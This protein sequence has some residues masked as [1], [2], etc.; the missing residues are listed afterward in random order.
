MSQVDCD[1]NIQ[2]D[3]DLN[4]QKKNN[5][6]VSKI[7][8]AR[9]RLIS[10][11]S[12]KE[13][14]PEDKSDQHNPIHISKSFPN[15]HG[16]WID[17]IKKAKKVKDPWA[18]FNIAELY[19]TERVQ[20]YRYQASKKK[21]IQ[22]IIFVKMETE[23]F[24]KGAMRKCFRMK[25]LPTTVHTNDWAY[26]NN[27]VAKIHMNETIMA[28]QYFDDVKLQMDAKLWAEEYNRRDP[29]KKIDIMQQ[30]CCKFIHR[31]GQPMYH[32]ENFIEGNYVKYNS[33]TGFVLHEEDTHV[34][35]TPQAFSHF[36]FERSGHQLII[37]DIQGVGD[38]YT[39]PQIHT[40][41]GDDYGD[42]N[43]GTKGMALFFG[44]HQCTEL[45]EK[46]NLK[47][48]DLSE[49]E[50]KRIDNAGSKS[51]SSTELKS[52]TFSGSSRRISVNFEIIKSISSSSL[53]SNEEFSEPP[54][55][56]NVFDDGNDVNNYFEQH[57]HI[58][59]SAAPMEELTQELIKDRLNGLANFQ[60]QQISTLGKVH[61]ELA[62]YNY[63]GRFT[64]TKPD[65]SSALFHLYQAA[66]C[67]DLSA[68][69]ILAYKYFNFHTDEFEDLLI[70]EDH[71]LGMNFMIEAAT[72]ND[73]DCMMKTAKAFD[74]GI[75][76]GKK[77]SQC[78]KE[79][80]KWYEAALNHH[81]AFS[82]LDS[83]P[84]HMIKAR[85]AEIWRCGGYGVEK[86]PSY[87]GEL[88]SSAAE[89]ALQLGK[90][91]LANSYLMLAE[92]SFGEVEE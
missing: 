5:S 12:I 87:A 39:D 49:E 50:K 69:K 43:L 23:P 15:S 73:K 62:T 31:E 81:S 58:S 9:S 36:T 10:Y 84:K 38:L 60:E 67:G 65:F 64:D 27:I 91:K 3:N 40:A 47:K 52:D 8:K 76:L 45:C 1:T 37:V 90:G 19:P 29:P 18:E 41:N 56:R 54:S 17:A 34:R 4:S 59:S 85:M 74:T 66:S 51:S 83:D 24:A 57:L 7:L 68:N 14:Y 16:N 25:K 21:W 78:W 6:E 79:A 20:R 92:E 22:D 77:R 33:N 82:C 86:D 32:I 44:T 70:Q 61:F 48:F 71:D 28:K 26:A 42:A 13:S 11:D 30:A 2:N 75:M 46:L 72:R 80:L 53:Q 63:I 35:A 55:P 88:Y 89:D